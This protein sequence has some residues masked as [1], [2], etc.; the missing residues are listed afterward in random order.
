[1]RLMKTI[2]PK[3]KHF[4]K[5]KTLSKETLLSLNT[6]LTVEKHKVLLPGGKIISDWS[7][8]ITPNVVIVVAITAEQNFLIFQQTKYAIDGMTLAPVG[9]MLE[10]GEEPLTAAQRELLEETGFTSE[11]WVKLGSYVLDPNHGIATINLYLTTNARK[12][13][14]PDANHKDLE[15]QQLTLLTRDEIRK[16]L[17]DGKFKAVQWAAAV[18][19]ALDYFSE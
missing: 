17:K 11:E 19:L 18:A 4:R 6:Y 9:G 5:W 8:I 10:P 7:W 2:S 14:Q 12:V 13:A 16:A 1:M 15:D 3:I